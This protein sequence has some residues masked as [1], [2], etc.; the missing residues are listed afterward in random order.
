[1]KRPTRSRASTLLMLFGLITHHVA[2]R[3]DGGRESL[4]IFFDK[5]GRPFRLILYIYQIVA[6]SL[7]V[8][9]L[10]NYLFV[11][12]LE[13]SGAIVYL[14]LCLIVF[15]VLAVGCLFGEEFG[16]TKI[17]V[18]HA[19]L[20]SLMVL[21]IGM[22]HPFGKNLLHKCYRQCFLLKINFTGSVNKKTSNAVKLNSWLIRHLLF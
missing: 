9:A 7:T 1:M 2:E 21:C 10:V 14:Y 13:V 18:S 11:P 20:G 4:A 22:Y 16:I 12:L 8:F 19:L 15:V 6:L 3:Q 17:K 5:F